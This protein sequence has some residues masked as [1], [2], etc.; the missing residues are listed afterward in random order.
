MNRIRKNHEFRLS[1]KRKQTIVLADFPALFGEIR[2]P[3]TNMLVLPKVSSELR[4]Y[5]PIAY[6]EPST[7]VNGS[8]L[9]IPDAELYHFSILTS[10]VHSAWLRRVGGRMKSDYQYSKDIVY[11]NFP[12]PELDQKAKVLLDETGKAIL[13]ARLQYPQLS[14]ANQYNQLLMPP[15]LRKA[16]II[17]DRVVWETYGRAWDITSE[18]ECIAY[19]MRL[20][21]EKVSAS[22]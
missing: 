9:M 22:N 18:D 10:N 11:N 19:L 3:S 1:S 2:Q 14:L 16:H 17:N 8:A 20:Y 7:I 13:E 6:I 5:L 12:W 15:E 4:K 21:E